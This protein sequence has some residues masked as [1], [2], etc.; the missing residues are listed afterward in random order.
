VFGEIRELCGNALKE[1]TIAPELPGAL[2]IILELSREDVAMS[3]GHSAASLED[4]LRAIDHG[5]SHVTH[6]FNAM[7]QMHHREPGLAGAALFSTDLT[8]EIIPDGNHVHP[9]M[10]GLVLQNK[11]VDLTCLV[12]DAMAMAGCDDGDYESLGEKVILERGKLTLKD[13][14]DTLAGSVL[15]MDRAVANMIAMVGVGIADAAAMASTTPAAVLGLDNR[16]GRIAV[17]YDADLAILDRRYETVMTI[18]GGTVVY[19]N[20]DYAPREGNDA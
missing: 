6:L 19:D 15:T 4:T 3:L 10:M 17:G 1:M 12:T 9:W 7:D 2:D 18:V 20:K 5:A 11:G 16:K 8:V 14:P 13:N